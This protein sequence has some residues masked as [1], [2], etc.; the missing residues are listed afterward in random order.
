MFVTKVVEFYEKILM[1]LEFSWQKTDVETMK[2]IEK[3]TN[4]NQTTAKN[5]RLSHP[6][7]GKSWKVFDICSHIKNFSFC[8]EFLHFFLFFSYK[9]CLEAVY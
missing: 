4:K 1:N 6:N 3:K 8:A 2:G 9:F 7:F 5:S